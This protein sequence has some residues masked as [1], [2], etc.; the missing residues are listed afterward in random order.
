MKQEKKFPRRIGTALMIVTSLMWFGVPQSAS[1]VSNESIA[2]PETNK[3][4]EALRPNVE[5]SYGKLPLSF[6]PNHGQAH[7]K[8]KY[9]S[10]GAGYLLLLTADQATL[11]LGSEQL[12]MKVEGGNS[13]AKVSAEAQLESVSNYLIGNNRK[14]W[15]TNV[16]NY[17]K[18]RVAKVYPEIDLVYYGSD[19]Q[20]LEFDFIV[21]AG[22]DPSKI[23]LAFEGAQSIRID[24]RG[25]LHLQMSNSEIIQ[26]APIIYQ[27]INGQRKNVS[28]RFRL[29]DSMKVKFEIDDYDQTQELIIDPKI[30]YASHHG[31]A[32]DDRIND[33]AV[34]KNGNAYIV[35]QTFS[36][37]LNVT[38]GVQSVKAGGM[39]AFIV[40]VNPA[41]TQR[42][43]STYL[44]GSGT[45]NANSVAIMS[46]GKI[47]VTGASDVDANDDLPTTSNRYMGPASVFGRSLDVFVTV[48]T[49]SGS[50]LFYSTFIGGGNNDIGAGIAVDASNK[51]Y[52][53]G[54]AL[55]DNFPTKNEFSE[56]S[57]DF[58][59]FI[60]KFDPTETGNDSLVYSSVIHGARGS[61]RSDGAR[62]AVTPNGVAFTTGTTG[63]NSLPVKSSSSLPPLQSTFKG[64]TQDG[65]IAKVSPAG[66]LIYLTYFGGDGT[67]TPTSIAVD[68]NE[69]AYIAGFTQSSSS[70][71]PLRNSIDS[72][73]NATADGFV[74]K[75]N[76]DGTTLFYSTFFSG[77]NGSNSI[78]AITVDTGGD[79]YLTGFMT[80]PQVLQSVN[81]FQEG[82][83]EGSM[84]V[85]KIERSNA[86]GTNT[87]RVLYFDMAGLG[88]PKGI[89]VDRRGNIFVAGST[90][91]Q[92]PSQLT[93]GVFQPN[94]AGP[95]NDGFILKIASTFGDTIGVFRASTNQFLLRNSN[96][97]GPADLTKLFGGPGDLPVAGDWNGD[98]IA[99]FG[100]F[101]PSTGQFFLKTNILILSQTFVI[102]FGTLGD[103]PI[104]GDWDG[105]GIDTIGVFR[106]ATGEFFLTDGPNINSTP[107]PSVVFSFGESGDLP[108]AGDFDGDGRDG[109]GVFRPSTGE[110]FLND[111]K[112]S[113]FFDA[114]FKFGAV[115]DFPVAGDWLGDGSDGVGVF[116][117]STGEF[118][119][120]NNNV[121][122]TTDLV[123]V[124][125]QNSDLPIAGNWNVSP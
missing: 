34:D 112:V 118:L 16:P 85:A 104:A 3:K 58:G 95:A 75:L 102:N 86:T 49:A 12:R 28:G 6:E 89:A 123:F 17:S 57:R 73:R 46:D 38:G 8:I 76:A 72:T 50:G 121:S 115:G 21:K 74:A 93:N 7:R 78:E 69:R 30:I 55:S 113:G 96:T 9:V 80:G 99:D 63:S 51:V 29:L 23:V 82:L 66:A 36:T 24:D 10:R 22:A 124:F 64:G 18:V 11:S 103:L 87:P 13:R 53:S 15:Q 33:V 41:G 52:V 70:T 35:G 39:D 92:L 94:F 108:I 81:G 119:L 110:F 47:A 14:E 120:N 56:A 114:G 2:V 42:V 116:R 61:G 60:A 100:F 71:F 125:G 25:D 122:N 84:F 32:A 106:P 109:V 26:P 45:D 1:I 97:S 59:A 79:V 105:D 43:F 98:G 91:I 88:G 90:S 77:T 48:L 107:V 83:P 4:Q 40:K 117:S 19:Q 44:G 62:I 5:E 27:Q 101:R 54:S 68:T 111:D 31:G 65:F 20:R 67:D 37:N